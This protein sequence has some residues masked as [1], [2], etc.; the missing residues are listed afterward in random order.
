[1]SQGNYESIAAIRKKDLTFVVLLLKN[2]I[3][4]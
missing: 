3:D 1:M 4:P 2:I